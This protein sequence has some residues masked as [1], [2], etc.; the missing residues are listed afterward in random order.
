MVCPKTIT[1]RWVQVT[2]SDKWQVV[3]S[4][5][6]HAVS[7]VGESK[8]KP[9]STWP[10]GRTDPFRGQGIGN[11]CRDL[12]E[13]WQVADESWVITV[14][15]GIGH[16]WKLTLQHKRHI[17]SHHITSYNSVVY[18]GRVISG[19]CKDRVYQAWSFALVHFARTTVNLSG[20]SDQWHIF[21]CQGPSSC[22]APTSPDSGLWTSK[23]CTWL[24][25]QDNGHCGDQHMDQLWWASSVGTFWM[26]RMGCQRCVWKW[27]WLCI[28]D[29]WDKT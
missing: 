27:Q 13:S 5:G 26:P 9:I 12:G 23:H 10:T 14:L 18:T 17:I 19:K 20:T 4:K 11:S 16:V 24:G 21:W 29:R 22:N 7:S 25:R 8:Q 28:Q 15:S 3:E 2:K 6:F 1:S